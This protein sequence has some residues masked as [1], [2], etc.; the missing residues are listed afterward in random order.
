MGWWWSLPGCLIC[1]LA[2]FWQIPNTIH[3][4]FLVK[5]ERG[6]WVNTVLEMFVCL[7]IRVN[8]TLLFYILG[9]T[10]GYCPYLVVF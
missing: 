8:D 1:T 4:T 9:A 2:E 3:S 7:C 10:P 6:I 5:K